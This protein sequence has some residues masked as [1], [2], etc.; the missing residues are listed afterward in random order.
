[1]SLKEEGFSLSLAAVAAES[2][3]LREK[4]KSKEAQRQL[5]HSENIY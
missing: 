1:M 3:G 4:S 2:G 5:L